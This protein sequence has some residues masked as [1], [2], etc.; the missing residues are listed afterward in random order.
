[1]YAVFDRYGDV[2]TSGIGKKRNFY[3][4]TRFLSELEP[5]LGNSRPFLLS[6]TAREDTTPG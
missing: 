5:F 1:M 4:G 2:E 6:S 3:Q